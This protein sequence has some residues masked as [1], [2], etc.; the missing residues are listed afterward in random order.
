MKYISIYRLKP[1]LKKTIKYLYFVVE[2]SKTAMEFLNAL[3]NI[4]LIWSVL[5]FF[6]LWMIVFG[7]L[8]NSTLENC[9][10]KIFSDAFRYGKTVR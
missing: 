1:Y 3:L 8:I 10:P 6:T 7:G 9:L 2:V 5:A 4:N